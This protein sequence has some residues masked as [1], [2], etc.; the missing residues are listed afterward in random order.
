MLYLLFCLSPGFCQLLS[1]DNTRLEPMCAVYLHSKIFF[2]FFVKI[3]P[4]PVNRNALIRYRTIDKCLQNR[5]RKWMIEDL[6][7]ACN[8]ALYEFEGIRRGVSLRTIRM[9]L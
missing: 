1:V 9:D 6:I 8:E 3:L 5:R 2:P 4:M 7:E